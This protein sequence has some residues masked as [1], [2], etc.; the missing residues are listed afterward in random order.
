LLEPNVPLGLQPQRG[1]L[2]PR[3]YSYEY[4]ELI[5]RVGN[6]MSIDIRRASVLAA[7]LASGILWAPAATMA[8]A[9]VLLSGPTSNAGTIDFST[10][11]STGYGGLMTV[12]SVTGYSLWGVLGGAKAS[13]PTSPIYGAITTITPAGDNGKNAILRYYVL[14]TSSGGSQS[15]ISLGEIDPNF[16]GSTTPDLV[17]F[18]GN[19]A[20]LAFTLP[21]A[22]GR[23]IIGLTSL[24]LL[25]VPAL[26]QVM[27]APPSSS[28]TLA[29]NISY[30]GAYTF[31]GADPQDVN[32]ITETVNGDTYT[33]PPLFAL[34][35]PSDPNTLNQY[36]VTAGTDGYEVLFSLAE[37]DPAFGASTAVN[38]V[39]LVPYADTNGDFPNDGLARVILPGDTPYAHGRWVSNLE[40]IDV[41]AVPEPA[42]SALLAPGLIGMALLTLCR[43]RPRPN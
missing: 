40:L 3:I 42:T 36:V 12:G 27:S 7:A 21:G 32:P 6:E 39:D 33:G 20:S 18:A 10:T 30:P 4:S 11:P 13:R 26:P 17:T 14:A 15:L 29:G 25:S 8:D 38:E 28:V 1:P 22:V 2:R 34:I 19:T 24:Q 5:K 35:D 31:Q 43:R 23:D 9:I 41:A 16:T 37:L